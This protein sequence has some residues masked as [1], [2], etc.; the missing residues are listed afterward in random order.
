MA[1]K[2]SL[3]KEN[4]KKTNS[5]KKTSSKKEVVKKEVIKK[6]EPI[7]QEIP[8][9]EVKTE[10]KESI[11][12]NTIIIIAS[13]IAVIIFLCFYFWRWYDVKKEERLMNSYLV[14]SGTIS[15]TIHNLD[16]VNQVL[17]SNETPDKYFVLINYTKNED[18]YNLEK[19]LKNIIDNYKLNDSFYYLDVTDLK[20]SNNNYIN[21]INKTFKTKDIKSIPT[22]L[23]YENGSLKEVVKR[24]DNN[25]INA[26]DFQKLLDIYEFEDQ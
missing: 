13:A 19:D 20:N 21:E 6:E 5:P 12:N 7:K 17:F 9:T 25:T 2:N 10:V 1:N 22:I 8:I 14:S 11:S 4:P 23:Y 26:G 15:L 18:N 16:E 24:I 3:A